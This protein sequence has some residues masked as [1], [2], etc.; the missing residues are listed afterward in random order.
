MEPTLSLK[1][2]EIQVSLGSP[3]EGEEPQSGGNRAEGA[4]EGGGCTQKPMQKCL[5]KINFL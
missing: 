1:M 4:E 2:E 3:R 5:N